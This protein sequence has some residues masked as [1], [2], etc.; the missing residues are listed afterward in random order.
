ME[1][2]KTEVKQL[3][4]ELLSGMLANPHVY[5][6][7]SDQLGRGQLEQD[8]IITAIEMAESLITKVEKFKTVP[9]GVG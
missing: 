6:M 3:A 5:P 8:L 9:R 7:V 2:Q 4:T 1:L